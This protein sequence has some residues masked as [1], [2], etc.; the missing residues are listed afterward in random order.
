LTTLNSRSI[1]F[2]YLPTRAANARR[3]R[4]SVL[5]IAPRPPVYGRSDMGENHEAE[6][7]AGTLA[8][9]LFGS[10]GFAA[11]QNAPASTGG[12]EKLI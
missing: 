1:Y 4:S 8:L 3:G 5:R 6:L 2:H 12:Q 9:A 7:H 11:A 10:G